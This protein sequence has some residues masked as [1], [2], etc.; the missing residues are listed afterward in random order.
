M[1]TISTYVVAIYLYWR[2]FWRGAGTTTGNP[3][4]V[5]GSAPAD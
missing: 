5:T 3:E 2:F 1:G 4:L